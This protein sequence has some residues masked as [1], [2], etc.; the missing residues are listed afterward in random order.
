M[1]SQILQQDHRAR[2]RVTAGSFHFG[3]H[4]VR[5]ELD[6]LAQQ[7]LE[8]H[9]NRLESE[10]GVGAS[11]RKQVQRMIAT[12]MYDEMMWLVRKLLIVAS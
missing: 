4:T 10:F 2:G 8:L 1:V 11:C 9:R 6:R 12:Y 7:R 3:P 5:E